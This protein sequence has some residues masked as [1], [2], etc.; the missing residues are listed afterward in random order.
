MYEK[1]CKTKKRKR[2]DIEPLQGLAKKKCAK[3]GGDARPNYTRCEACAK[4]ERLRRREN[5]L[6]EKGFFITMANRIYGASVERHN[7]K[8]RVYIGTC[9]MT[10]QK[11]I[12]LYECQQRRCA[13][14]G[15][16]LT[17]IS[18]SHFMVS[19]DRIVDNKDYD[20]NTRF[21]ALE[22]N[23]RVKWSP[24]KLQAFCVAR[25]GTL[26]QKDREQRLLS[27]QRVPPRKPST[28]ES[29]ITE[30]GVVWWR[31]TYCYKFKL[32][33]E[34]H[35]NTECRTCDKTRRTRTILSELEQLLS[36]ACGNCEQRKLVKHNNNSVAR[37]TIAQATEFK[38]DVEFLCNLLIQQ[39]FRCAYSRA[40]FQFPAFGA[41]DEC[42][43]MSLERKDPKHGYTPGNVCLIARAFQSTDRSRIAKYGGTGSGGWTKM[44]VDYVFQWMDEKRR[45][46]ATPT[47]TYQEY[48]ASH[49]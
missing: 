48:C 35:H 23:T 37:E 45:G 18:G 26:D 5:Y 12:V 2:K 7:N 42:F 20:G 27:L 3:C 9:T 36:H 28:S 13:I 24:A 4:K 1:K 43:R 6:T 30:D 15:I 8:H 25:S 16:P 47:Q 33:N 10:Y 41:A 38:L 49:S 39:D 34:M 29:V 11:L 22:F 46:L 19:P 44:K 21:V 32:V 40:L 31:C 14:S 17:H